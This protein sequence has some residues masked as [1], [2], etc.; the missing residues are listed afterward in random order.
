MLSTGTA[1]MRAK[2]VRGTP[3]DVGAVAAAT[4]S[5]LV[6]QPVTGRR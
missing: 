5:V 6:P 4:T 2:A 1:G 3:A